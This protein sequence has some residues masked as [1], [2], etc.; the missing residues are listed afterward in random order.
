MNAPLAASTLCRVGYGDAVLP[1]DP[2]CIRVP[3]VQVQGDSVGESWHSTLPVRSGTDNGICYA[4]NGEVLM[5]S[6]SVSAESLA[7]PEAA[8][9]DLYSRLL[10]FV[11][12]RGYPH[13][14]RVWNYLERINQGEADQERYRQFCVGRHRALANQPHFEMQLPAASAIGSASGGLKVHA[15]AGRQPGLQVENPRQVSAF[16][17]PRSYGARSPSFSRATLTPWAD[18]AQ[19][20]ASGT[21]SIVGHAT[22]HAGDVIA[23]LVQTAANLDVLRTHAAN[24][25]LP[26][27]AAQ[28]LAP[29]LYTVYLRHAEDL[30][31][32]LPV[33]A[34]RFAEAPCKVLI[35]DI[36]RSELLIEV[37]ASYRVAGANPGSAS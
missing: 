12:A 35:G 4:D 18:G 37:E 29:E 5:L 34:E 15:F 14:L 19:L 23:Q 21:A 17:Y 27:T 9:A 1:D 28:F 30:P 24:S 16:R 3:L 22:A 36:C 25:L 7:D 10:A 20:F 2:R 26:G 31:Q 11:T 8:A 32:V 6:L 33:L 13:L